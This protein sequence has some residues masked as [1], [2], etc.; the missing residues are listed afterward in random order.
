PTPVVAEDSNGPFRL[1]LKLSQP[2]WHHNEPIPGEA[3]LSLVGMDMLTYGSTSSG[4]IIFRF[5]EIGGNRE[6]VEPSAA[7]CHELTLDAGKPVVVPIRFP[8]PTLELPIG[9]WRIT[10]DAQADANGICPQTGL[11]ASVEGHVIP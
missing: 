10:A 9:T 1:E 3:T 4:P 5:K 11:T 8:G 6:F 2:E 7:D